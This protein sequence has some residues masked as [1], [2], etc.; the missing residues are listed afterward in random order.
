[1]NDVER[2]RCWPREIKFFLACCPNI[3]CTAISARFY[4]SFKKLSKLWPKKSHVDAECSFIYTHVAPV[5]ACM[6]MGENIG[7]LEWQ[8]KW[9]ICG[10]SRFFVND[11]LV[12]K[13]IGGFIVHKSM[14]R[15]VD[16]GAVDVFLYKG[17]SDAR[18]KLGEEIFCIWVLKICCSPVERVGSLGGG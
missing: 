7:V 17:W 10:V 13:C 4:T 2:A 18:F 16:H 9:C 8:L 11:K 6:A 14:V 15:L 12:M 1:M 3:L 5:W